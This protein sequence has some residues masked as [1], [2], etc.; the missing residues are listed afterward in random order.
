MWAAQTLSRRNPPVLG[1]RS[2]LKPSPTS[3][4]RTIKLHFELDVQ[5]AIGFSTRVGMSKVE[6]SGVSVG[7]D[8]EDGQGH[9]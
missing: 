9:A 5:T 1:Y 6:R 2:R 3:H 8:M 7:E 4:I